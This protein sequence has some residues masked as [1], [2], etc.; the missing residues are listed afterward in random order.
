MLRGIL[1]RLSWQQVGWYTWSCSLTNYSN[2]GWGLCPLSLCDGLKRANTP[3]TKH[4]PDSESSWVCVRVQ[5]PGSPLL[6]TPIYFSYSCHGELCPWPPAEINGPFS[7]QALDW[8]P[9]P[10][11]RQ[12]GHSCLH[13]PQRQIDVVLLT[14]YHHQ[15][16][17]KL[18]TRSLNWV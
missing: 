6:N 10:P 15:R 16:L 17:Q 2:D 7:S 8:C 3:H 18:E 14:D 13:C 4:T 12:Y 11:S 1:S 5:E 9:L